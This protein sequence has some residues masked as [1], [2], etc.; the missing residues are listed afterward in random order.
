MNLEK[1]Y[2]RQGASDQKHQDYKQGSKEGRHHESQDQV[3]SQES[4]P[5]V[6]LPEGSGLFQY[7]V[8]VVLYFPRFVN[9]FISLST[10]LLWLQEKKKKQK[11]HRFWQLKQKGVLLTA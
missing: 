1:Q 4:H 9:I 3:P 6:T 11:N 7:L 5:F 10:N 8:C 2:T